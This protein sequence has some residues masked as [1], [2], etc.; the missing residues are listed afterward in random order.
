MQPPGGQFVSDDAH[1]NRLDSFPGGA[2]ATAEVLIAMRKHC[3]YSPSGDGA[4]HQSQEYGLAH[5]RADSVNAYLSS[6]TLDRA[7]AVAAFRA[8]AHWASA[9]GGTSTANDY[10]PRPTPSPVDSA[11][12]ARPAHWQRFVDTSAYALVATEELASSSLVDWI[13]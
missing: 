5:Q 13:N 2:A 1:G 9:V 7:C 10:T 4:N 8:F 3:L 11:N 12:A 6:W